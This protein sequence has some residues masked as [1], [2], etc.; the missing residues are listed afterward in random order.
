MLLTT[1]S[2]LL[3]IQL[4]SLLHILVFKTIL[5]VNI[6]LLYSFLPN[7]L[8]LP[9]YPTFSSFSK[10]RKSQYNT[11]P[12]KPKN[13]FLKVTQFM[14]FSPPVTMSL[15]LLKHKDSSTIS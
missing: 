7:P 2:S 1:D 10:Q 9:T 13:H 3:P 12:L 4:L 5:N 6:V 14:M 11:K 8:Y 15:H